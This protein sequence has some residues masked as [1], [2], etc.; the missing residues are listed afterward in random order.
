MNKTQP[1]AF[2][3]FTPVSIHSSR[4]KI[5]IGLTPI[6]YREPT[7]KER[8]NTNKSSQNTKTTTFKKTMLPA[9]TGSQ[10]GTAGQAGWLQVWDIV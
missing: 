6:P 1:K 9:E 7:L 3:N 4:V 2:L 8:T 10:A 5:S